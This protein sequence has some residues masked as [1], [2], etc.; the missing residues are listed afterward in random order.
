MKTDIHP[1]YHTIKFVC[2]CGAE[3]KVGSTIKDEVFQTEICA[4]CHPFFTGK[5]KIIDS[6]GRVDK[7]MA[8]MKKAQEIQAS[9]SKKVEKAEPEEA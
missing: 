8:K 1:A 4:N 7:F 3:Y 5:Q 9:N 2:A 6:S